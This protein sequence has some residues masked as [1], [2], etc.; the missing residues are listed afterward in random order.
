MLPSDLEALHGRPNALGR[1]PTQ[2][3]PSIVPAD[4]YFGGAPIDGHSRTFSQGS[5]PRR[6]S[7][8]LS[9]GQRRRP[10]ENSGQPPQGKSALNGYLST[11]YSNNVSAAP[12]TTELVDQGSRGSSEESAKKP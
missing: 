4:T 2:V 10:S 1:V 12:T 5:K 11:V 6:Q 7:S 8:N 3:E 9:N